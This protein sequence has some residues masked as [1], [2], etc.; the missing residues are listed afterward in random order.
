MLEQQI[1]PDQL[2]AGKSQGGA[3]V[4][5]KV[6][7]FELENF[8]GRKVE[9]SAECKDVRV[10]TLEKVASIVVDSGPW[11]GFE[12]QGFSGE[13]F[14]LEKGDYPRWTTWTNSQRSCFLM[15]LRPVKVDGPDHKLLLFEGAG[16]S[17]RKMEIMD[18]DVPSLWGYGFH[19][20]VA[21]IK[22]LNGTWVA[23]VYPGYRGHQFVLEKGD[24]KHWNEW[25]GSRPQIQ[26]V[27]RVRDMQWHKRGRFTVP[28]PA[29]APTPTPPASST[30]GSS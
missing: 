3:S 13:Q 15:S 14:I 25:Q 4:T 17:G 7:L 27:R 9:L 21:S 6:V 8:Q 29:P 30:T 19:D 5:Y 12:C 10:K 16:F 26:S 20:R 18:E 1:D 11:V 24:Y 2:A 23:Y 28:A 22:A